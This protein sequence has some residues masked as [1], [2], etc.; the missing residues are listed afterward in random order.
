MKLVANFHADVTDA[1]NLEAE[2]MIHDYLIDHARAVKDM[3]GYR[4]SWDFEFTRDAVTWQTLDVKRDKHIDRSGN[5]PFEV[6]DLYDDLRIRP[7]WGVNDDLDWLA[8]VNGDLTQAYIASLAKVRSVAV[9]AYQRGWPSWAV[10][11]V[12]SY[13][14]R[15]ITFGVAL[16]MDALERIGVK[17]RRVDLSRYR[18]AA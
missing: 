18:K 14:S 3:R 6:Y 13:G 7:T 8:V 12:G 17:I 2:E 9:A 16:R 5:F 4:H 1:D 10:P 15:Y 11:N